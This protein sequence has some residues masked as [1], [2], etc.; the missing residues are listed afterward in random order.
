[1]RVHRVYP[2]NEACVTLGLIF[3][4]IYFQFLYWKLS[5]NAHS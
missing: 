4:E 5:L 2:V 1:M 3:I